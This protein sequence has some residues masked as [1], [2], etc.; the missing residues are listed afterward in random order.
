[1][2]TEMG[3]ARRKREEGRKGWEDENDARGEEWAKKEKRKEWAEQGSRWPPRL[4]IGRIDPGRDRREKMCESHGLQMISWML[5]SGSVPFSVSFFS[6][7]ST[8][9]HSASALTHTHTQLEQDHHGR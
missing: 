4:G 9:I 7:S 3:G 8:P 2:Q 5:L 1:M 6:F